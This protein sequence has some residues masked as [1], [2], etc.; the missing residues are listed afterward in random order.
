M[1]T[2]NKEKIFKWI[3]EDLFYTKSPEMDRIIELVINK[4]QKEANSQTI[5]NQNKKFDGSA[6]FNR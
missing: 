3:K 2:F 4:C 5:Y 6:T 1:I